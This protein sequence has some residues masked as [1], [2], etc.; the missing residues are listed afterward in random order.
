MFFGLGYSR[1]VVSISKASVCLSLVYVRRV[2]RGLAV[3]C[4]F[5]LTHR[6][7]APEHKECVPEKCMFLVGSSMVL[8][9]F[10]AQDM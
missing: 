9:S 4:L 10:G 7:L 5:R 6:T 1:D 2:N 3:L 8:S